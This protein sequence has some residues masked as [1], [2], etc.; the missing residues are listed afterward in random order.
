MASETEL[1]LQAQARLKG[2]TQPYTGTILPMSI[3]QNG[4]YSW[5]VPTALSNIPQSAISAATLPGQ[6]YSGEKPLS[7][8]T[9]ADT[10]NFATWATPINPAV[11]AGDKAIPGAAMRAGTPPSEKALLKQAGVD[12]QNFYGTGANLRADVMREFARLQKQALEQKGLLDTNAPTT[13][14]LLDKITQAPSGN[15]VFVTPQQ[16]QAFREALGNTAGNYAAPKDQLAAVQSIRKLD[17]FFS[18]AA[19]HPEAFVA[20]TTPEATRAAARAFNDARGNYAAA[21]ASQR[22]TGKID[23]A[24][25]RAAAANSGRNL[26]NAIRQRIAGILASEPA[27][28]G[29]TPQELQ[30]MRDLVE[31][32]PLTNTLRDVSNRLGGGGGM[33]GYLA[34]ASVGGSVAYYTGSPEMGAI[35]TGGVLGAGL[36]MKAGENALT[37]NAANNIATAIRAR[38]PMYMNSPRIA[39]YPTPADLFM[40]SYMAS[41]LPLPN[42]SQLDQYLA[43]NPNSM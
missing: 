9:P 19:D 1:R 30:M 13:H 35:A 8:L 4:Q 10:L 27:Q 22:V 16:F 24:E 3:D 6:V 36:A 11:R 39:P 18:A 23:A 28:A 14:A 2:Q 21:K 5:S 37:K 15:D 17:G 34:P 43:A 12:Y 26:D 42:P 38:S 33:H 25:L 29:Y 41:R 32:N 20:G 7:D 40:R 31:G